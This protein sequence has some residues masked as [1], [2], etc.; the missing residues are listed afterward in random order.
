MHIYKNSITVKKNKCYFK[1]KNSTRKQ[2]E[3][4]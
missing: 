2:C 3:S 1:C 4:K